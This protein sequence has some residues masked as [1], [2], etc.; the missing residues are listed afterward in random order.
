MSPYRL[1]ARHH[2]LRRTLL[3]VLSALACMAPAAPALAADAPSRSIARTPSGALADSFFVRQISDDG[4]RVLG[5]MNSTSVALRDLAAGTTSYLLPQTNV[6]F[7][8]ASPDLRYVIA[9][10]SANG[11]IPGDTDN[12]YDLFCLDRQ[13]GTIQRV[14]AELARMFDGTKADAREQAEIQISDDLRYVTYSARFV[15]FPR[16]D[17]SPQR[18]ESSAWRWDRTTGRS[19]RLRSLPADTSF[20]FL[21]ETDGT[22]RVTVSGASIY[23]GTRRI[24][25]PVPAGATSTR[26]LVSISD[27]GDTVAYI[28]EADGKKLFL[29]STSTGEI[30]ATIDVPMQT[31]PFNT[32]PVDVDNDGSAA[33]LWT[34]STRA[35]GAIRDQV[36]RAT[37]PNQLTQLGGDI[38]AFA[39]SSSLV[40]S[41][42]RQFATN[43]SVVA[44]L[45]SLPLPGTEPPAVQA[46]ITT[47][48]S[49]IDA[50]CARNWWGQ[51]YN[52]KA[53]ISL[54]G[55]QRGADPR[56][57]ASATVRAYNTTTPTTFY[58]PVLSV[59]P[60]SFV[61]VSVPT[62]GGW[63]YSIT[64]TFT[65]GSTQSD[66]VDIAPHAA[67]RC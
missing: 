56:T 22:G 2:G 27:G 59:K 61:Q 31:A 28:P 29:I 46:P 24:P 35:D 10:T 67:P 36:L 18:A 60:D 15:I 6:L 4:G 30:T 47:W 49:Y 63:S 37:A 3:T 38:P 13:T 21:G 51:R 26:G 41:S 1:A 65:D 11:V 32:Y 34:R 25:L 12:Q 8:K 23:V 57:P 42:N 55:G 45:G 54:L 44:Q 48:T 39:N 16:A 5:T 53:I 66:V 43:G 52:T 62:T 17:G 14:S 40:L 19:T 50:S 9:G 20:N 64:I 33:Y 58:S 7:Y